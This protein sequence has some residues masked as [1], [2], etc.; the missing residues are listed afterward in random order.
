[1][2]PTE[3]LLKGSPAELLTQEREPMAKARFE[4]SCSKCGGPVSK[5]ET[6]MDGKKFLHGLHG[7]RCAKDGAVSVNRKLKKEE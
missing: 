4:Y 3:P 6:A 7:W 5:P 2:A 1:M